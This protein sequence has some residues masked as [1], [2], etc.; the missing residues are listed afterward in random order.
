MC[1]FTP[2]NG[3]EVLQR[4]AGDITQHDRYVLHAVTRLVSGTRYS[5]F[6]VDRGNGLGE[7]SVIEADLQL[8]TN[9]L[10]LIQHEAAVASSSHPVSITFSDITIGEQIG[11]GAFK[12]VYAGTWAARRGDSVCITQHHAGPG[13]APELEVL[14]AIGRHPNLVRFYGY[15]LHLG[16]CYFVVERAPFGSLREYLLG[17]EESGSGPLPPIIA[18]E[19][20][21]QACRAMQQLSTLSIIHRDLAARN[22]LVFAISDRSHHDVL[23]KVNDFGLS[24]HSSVNCYYGDSVGFPVRWSAPEVLQRRKYTEKSDVWAL[25]VVLWE[26]F[27]LAMVPYFEI[28]TD[29]L[30]IQAVV[31]GTKLTRPVDCPTAIFER[32]IVPCWASRANERPDFERLLQSLRTMQEALL[33]Q[34][35]PVNDRLCCICLT[36]PSSYAI[37]PCGHLCLCDNAVCID[38]FQP[39]HSSQCPICRNNV[40]S[41]LHTFS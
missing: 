17:V 30:V 25:G 14:R 27:S 28:P 33:V 3:V 41:I 5:L 22:I 10:A 31:E 2:Q 35:A 23:V 29:Q 19:I 12:T 20:A 8:V 39:P 11:A 34:Q 6:V 4:Q 9:I 40:M 13:V 37:F 18:L 38:P 1:Y 26:I 36:R 16:K 21:I 15:S 24:R 7:N 32:C